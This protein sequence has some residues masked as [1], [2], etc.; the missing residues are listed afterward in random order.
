[1][2]RE[3][4]RFEG[5]LAQNMFGLDPT[6]SP[7]IA[8]QHFRELQ[9]SQVVQKSELGKIHRTFFIEIVNFKGGIAENM[10]GTFN[11]FVPGP[12]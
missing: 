11:H 3:T 12:G 4:A 8:A 9:K 5:E 1:M 6:G 2:K 7:R 10:F